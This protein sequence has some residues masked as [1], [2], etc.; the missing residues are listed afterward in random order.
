M[1]SSDTTL[2]FLKD[3]LLKKYFS[4]TR[5]ARM[6]EKIK[7]FVGKLI[8][9]PIIKIKGIYFLENYYYY[10]PFHSSLSLK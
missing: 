1:F 6:H 3:V 2:V 4:E 8:L 7:F 5:L 10:V 9:F